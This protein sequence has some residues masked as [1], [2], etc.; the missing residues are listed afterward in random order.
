MGGL[1]SFEGG[2]Q[3][4]MKSSLGKRYT[5]ESLHMDKETEKAAKESITDLV[6]M[7]NSLGP[8]KK[9]EFMNEV[10]SMRRRLNEEQFEEALRAKAALYGIVLGDL[11]GRSHEAKKEEVD[12]HRSDVPLTASMRERIAMIEDHLGSDE[13]IKH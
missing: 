13:E 5:G 9:K 4:E 10:L 11:P 7:V 12:E 6:N 3:G 2:P 8:V 1:R